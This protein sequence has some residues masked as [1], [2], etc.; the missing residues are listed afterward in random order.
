MMECESCHTTIKEKFAMQIFHEYVNRDIDVCTDCFG[1]FLK[2]RVKAR[3]QRLQI[4]IS[5]LVQFAA[6][7]SIHM[8][9]DKYQP[10]LGSQ[11]HLEDVREKLAPPIPW[12]LLCEIV[13][14]TF[15][16]KKPS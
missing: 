9:D 3:K 15:E 7:V 4:T 11:R 2:K 12:K 6:D 5:P 8:D 1:A 14:E 13:P 16:P 10:Q